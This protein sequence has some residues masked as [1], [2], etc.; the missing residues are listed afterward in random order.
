LRD[1]KFFA[2]VIGRNNQII[3]RKAQDIKVK[4]HSAPHEN[5]ESSIVPPPDTDAK[6]RTYSESAKKPI[7]GTN[8][9]DQAPECSSRRL[10]SE[11]IEEDERF[12][13]SG[14]F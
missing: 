11:S 7:P 8:S 1:L 4:N 14:K 9:G 2:F 13:M 12:D 10:S 3:H 5:K 6:P